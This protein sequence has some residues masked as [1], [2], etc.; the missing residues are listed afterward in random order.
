MIRS[1]LPI[2]QA[3]VEVVAKDHVTHDMR[4]LSGPAGGPGHW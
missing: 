1:G 4:P 2:Q 3:V